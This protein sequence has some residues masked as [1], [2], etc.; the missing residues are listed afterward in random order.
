MSAQHLSWANNV[1]DIANGIDLLELRAENRE[2]RRCPLGTERLENKIVKIGTIARLSKDKGLDILIKAVAQIQNAEL[3]IVGEG[4]EKANLQ[5]LAKHFLLTKEGRGV[6]KFLSTLSRL[7]IINFYNNIDIFIL[8]SIEHDPFGLVVAE[9]MATK[10]ATI[11]T[12]VCGITD[13]LKDF[14]DTRII[15]AKNS[16][17]LEDAINWYIKN[18]EEK[19][20]ITENAHKKCHELFNVEKMV[21]K[22]ERLFLTSEEF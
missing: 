3:L 2:P 9:A 6:V 1:V 5:K 18:P 4:P 19:E 8:P 20:K 21:N 16:Q 15:S 17:V 11:V 10:V 12:N 22:Y 14:E 13:Y 7:E